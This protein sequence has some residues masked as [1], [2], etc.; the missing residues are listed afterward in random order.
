MI[1]AGARASGWQYRA[2]D[3]G[4]TGCGSHGVVLEGDTGKRGSNAQAEKYMHDAL[5]T[6][7]S[8]PMAENSVTLGQTGARSVPGD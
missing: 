1:K 6:D 8:P 7:C 5:Q 2:V 4:L 3:R